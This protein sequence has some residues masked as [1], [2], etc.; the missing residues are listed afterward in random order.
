MSPKEVVYLPCI[1]CPIKGRRPR[2]IPLLSGGHLDLRIVGNHGHA[3]LD[4]GFIGL[5]PYLASLKLGL[6]SLEFTIFYDVQCS[7]ILNLL[8]K[9]SYH[10]VHCRLHLL[11]MLFLVIFKLDLLD[12]LVHALHCTRYGLHSIVNLREP[13]FDEDHHILALLTALLRVAGIGHT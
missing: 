6:T 13:F 1:P 12:V 11:S 5:N 2:H 3:H 4:V 10:G 8:V 9:V 7:R